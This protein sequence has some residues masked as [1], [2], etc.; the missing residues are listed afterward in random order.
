M[1]ITNKK[2]NMNKPNENYYARHLYP[3]NNFN[4]NKSKKCIEN[5]ININSKKNNEHF[6]GRK[7]NFLS[8]NIPISVYSHYGYFYNNYNSNYM[9]PI[10]NNNYN[11]NY[12][13]PIYNN[14]N[15][16][17]FNKK[18][19]IKNNEQIIKNKYIYNLIKNIII[20][21]VLLIII[22][23]LIIYIF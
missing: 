23:I 15:N 17:I 21:S 11:S 9:Y 6:F 19:I 18:F 20:I 8:S 5:D 1:N 4:I 3:S 12:M 22:S 16:I 14:N 13:Y 2:C 10:Y 7:S